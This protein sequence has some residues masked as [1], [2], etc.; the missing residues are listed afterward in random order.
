MKKTS[1]FIILVLL[2][3]IA[4]LFLSIKELEAVDV[5]RCAGFGTRAIAQKAFNDNPEKYAWADRDHDNKACEN[6]PINS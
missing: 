1:I 6:L 4:K 3:V 2:L 5:R